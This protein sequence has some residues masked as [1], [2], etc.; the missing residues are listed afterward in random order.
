[1]QRRC[2]KAGAAEEHATTA[3]ELTLMS[4]LSK[5]RAYFYGVGIRVGKNGKR[6]CVQYEGRTSMVMV[7]K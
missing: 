2:W 3:L 5:L 7:R 1:L 6:G 4:T